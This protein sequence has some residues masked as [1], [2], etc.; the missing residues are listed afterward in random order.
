[1][2]M[3][4]E[5]ILQIVAKG[6]RSSGDDLLGFEVDTA[7]V[8]EM[9]GRFRT[10]SCARTDDPRSLLEIHAVAN[11]DITSLQEVRNALLSVW[12]KIAYADYGAQGC[13][14]Y[15]DATVMRFVTCT[16]NLELCV[17][18]T[19]TATAPHYADL[20]AA[21]ERDFHVLES[22]PS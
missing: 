17:T 14:W 3:I 10:F 8:F 7:Y 16:D 4:E 2:R 9:S 11:G 13:R 21:F 12:T 6:R 1:M 20:A 22:R 18:G 15:K 19:I 5:T